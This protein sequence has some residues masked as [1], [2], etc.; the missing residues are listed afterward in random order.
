MLKISVTSIM[1]V[2]YIVNSLLMVTHIFLL[3]L[4]YSEKPPFFRIDLLDYFIYN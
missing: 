4:Y 3:S 1:K 2:N